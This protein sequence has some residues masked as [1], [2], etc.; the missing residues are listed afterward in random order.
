MGA[1]AM[2]ESSWLRRPH[3]TAGFE[4]STCVTDQPACAATREAAP[5]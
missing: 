2:P 1:S 4:A 3:A 5:V